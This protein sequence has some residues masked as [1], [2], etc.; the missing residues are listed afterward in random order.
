MAQP[1]FP[2]FLRRAPSAADGHPGVGKTSPASET[3]CSGAALTLAERFLRSAERFPERPALVI[4]GKALTY[5]ALHRRAAQIARAILDSGCARGEL[6]GIFAQRSHTA[7]VGILGAVMAGCGYVPL[8]PSFP[9][10][11]LRSMSEGVNVLITEPQAL[12]SLDALLAAAAEPITVIGPEIER[13]GPL[14]LSLSR[15]RFVGADEIDTLAPLPEARRALPDDI[16]YL[17]FTSGSTGAPKGV[18]VLQRNVGAYLDHIAERF[19][20][21][22]DD[23]ASQTFELTF[24]LSV[25]D[26]FATWQA[27]ASLCVLSSRA[28]FAPA[29][30]IV[31]HGLTVWFSVPSVAMMM[32]RL[33]LLRPGAFPTLRLAL[34][35]GEALPLNTLR[36]WSA[37]AP[38]ARVENLYGPTE[39]T[40]AITGFRWAGETST[41]LCR[42]GIV[43][44]GMPFPGQRAELA[45]ERGGLV[46]GSGRGEL[47]LAGTQVTTGYWRAPD[48]TASRF[49]RLPGCPDLQWY[50]TGDIVERDEEGCLHFVGRADSQI[51]LNGNRIELQEVDAA[52]REATG[53]DLAVS[54]LGPSAEDGLRAIVGCIDAAITRDDAAVLRR[55]AEL[56]P[57]YMMPARL[58]RVRGMPL[59][60]NGKIDRAALAQELERIACTPAEQFED[61]N[62]APRT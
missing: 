43:P 6:V 40:I 61:A 36:L 59:N 27:G 3:T 25:H 21:G 49:I 8:N 37:A 42:R 7:F 33:R 11:R 45:D 48:Q 4:G 60:I 17:L 56:L 12:D 38:N 24:D 53:S 52:L 13:F 35:C 1:P 30:F 29:R 10:A 5:A 18:P 47:L 32:A 22:P 19:D 57:A 51:K 54:V 26:L 39:A 55:C 16:A 28:V 44:I 58:H 2:L 9:T 31:D 46:S 62:P 14:P 23:R 34:F 20:L 50:R 41:R 15:H